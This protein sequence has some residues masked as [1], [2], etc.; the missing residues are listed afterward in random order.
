MARPPI[1]RLAPFSWHF[2]ATL[3]DESAF[4]STKKERI[5]VG[6]NPGFSVDCAG[7]PTDITARVLVSQS[8]GGTGLLVRVP[9]AVIDEVGTAARSNAK[10]VSDPGLVLAIK[11]DDVATSMASSVGSAPHHE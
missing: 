2:F 9:G 8:T 3:Y 6:S 11:T 1:P 4:L 7:P 10:D 5:P